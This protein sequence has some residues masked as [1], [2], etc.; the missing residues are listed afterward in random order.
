[1]LNISVMLNVKFKRTYFIGNRN[2]S[3]Q[4]TIFFLQN[5]FI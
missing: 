4:C 1:M 5:M 3:N 2:L